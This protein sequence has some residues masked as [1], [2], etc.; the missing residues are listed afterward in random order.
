MI[1][2]TDR[3][4][5]TLD[6]SDADF[7]NWPESFQAFMERAGIDKLEIEFCG[8]NSKPVKSQLELQRYRIH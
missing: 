4:N 8:P 6:C 2:N 1:P 3:S 7:T 5:Q